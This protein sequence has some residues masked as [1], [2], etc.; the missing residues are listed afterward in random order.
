M[1]AFAAFQDALFAADKTKLRALVTE[2]SAVAIDA[3]SF[4][5]VRSQQ[6]LVA[7]RA[8]DLRG[9]W[10]VQAKDPNHG[11]APAD[12]LITRENG[13]YV[14]DLLATAQLHATENVTAAPRTFVPRELTPADHDEIRRRELAMPP[15]SP[16]R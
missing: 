4:D 9:R 14:V 8:E 6:R 10:L 5:A 15:S 2:E 11:N 1:A 7:T 13:H 16:A 3:M 12:F